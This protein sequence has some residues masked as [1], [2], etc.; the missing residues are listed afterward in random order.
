MTDYYFNTTSGTATSA[1]RAASYV[2]EE[3]AF[4]PLPD[5]VTASS[6]VSWGSV[7]V[8]TAFSFQTG[9]QP[10]AIYPDFATAYAVSSSGLFFGAD[11]A[12][13]TAS[14]VALQT[15]TPEPPPSG[16]GAGLRFYWG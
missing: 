7:A 13:V 2:R 11:L 8:G 3:I 10:P 6:N 1:V 9:S 12:P 15:D 5:N 16:G 14:A 4:T